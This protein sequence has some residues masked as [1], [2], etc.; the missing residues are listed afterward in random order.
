MASGL[1]NVLFKQLVLHGLT[2]AGQSLSVQLPVCRKAEIKASKI[3]HSGG[4]MM[5]PIIKSSLN[6]VI[7][8]LERSGKR[9]KHVLVGVVVGV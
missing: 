2:S 7:F 9:V 1:M 8:L 4:R 3:L 6:P 5:D